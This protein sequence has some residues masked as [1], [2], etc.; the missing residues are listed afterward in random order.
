MR[1]RYT[2]LEIARL[3]GGKLLG[4]NHDTV[5]HYPVMDSRKVVF[6]E[7]SLFIAIHGPH[8]NG[9]QYISD[10]IKQ[11]VK[12]FLVSDEEYIKPFLNQAG[13]IVVKNTLTAFQIIAAS[14]RNE[15]NGS[16]V[17]I[18]GSNGKT[19]VKDWLSHVLSVQ[20]NVC[21]NPKSYNSQVGVPI[22]LWN[23][24]PEHE[25]G[26]FEAGI[27]LPGEMK[28]LESMIRPTLG[29]FTNIGSAHEENF[30][31]QEEKIREKLILFKHSEGIII[32]NDDELIYSIA[33]EIYPDKK[34]ITWGNH[35]DCN[36]HVSFKKQHG[37]CEIFLSSGDENF[38]YEIPFTDAASIENSIHVFIA[39]L[40]LGIN[41]NVLIEQMKLLPRVNMRLSFKS[42]KNNCFIIDDTYSNDFDSLKIAVDSLV[43]LHQFQK[44]TIIL[45]DIVQSKTNK[46]VLYNEVASLLEQKGIQRIIGIGKEIS[47][48]KTLFKGTAWFYPTIHACLDKLNSITFKDEAILIKGARVFEL[49][50][51]VA[52]LE[53]KVH[54]T[55][56]EVNLNAMV[57]N[58]N[59]Y[60]K[61]IPA[62]TKIMAMVKASGYGTGTHEIAH[63]LHFHHIDYLAVAYADEGIELRNH[64]I[65]LPIM[66]MNA[67]STGINTLLENKLEPVIYNF[68]TLA[69]YKNQL[70]R[71]GTLP[72]VHIEIDTGMHRLGFNPSS[73]NQLCDEI[74][75]INGLIVKS[76][77]SHL[78]GSD[79]PGLDEFTREQ[80]KQFDLHSSFIEK[81]LGYK[82]I[83]HIANSAG[84]SRFKEAAFDM[85]RLGVGLYGVGANTEEQSKLQPVI[86]LYS[87][88]AQITEVKPGD[89]IGYGRSFIA[90]KSMKIATVPIGYAD[91]YRRSLGNGQGKMFIN[92]KPANVVG[93]V[94]MDM[95]MID[96]TDLDIS[97]GDRVEIIGENY[98]I[99]LFARSI[100]TIPYEVLTSI[101]QRV[102]RI[103]TQE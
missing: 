69:H 90:N 44:K 11:G 12:C 60:R 30:K 73:I 71:G 23:L 80:I 76:V 14:H 81:A 28:K 91:G 4:K 55:I 93:R 34:L 9:H 1:N 59:Y 15:F 27:S 6:P 10:V 48:F 16:L 3:T 79:E 66:V 24:Q 39:A 86:S 84:A 18:T 52:R 21:K 33:K 58:L 95:T 82:T 17:G 29:I 85:V 57:H 5:V 54:D 20:Y 37:N 26:V 64:G 103:Y 99:E 22:S 67:E 56:L 43:S 35:P 40:Y 72:T 78:A 92:G 61:H 36:Y 77:F 97:V 51:L 68:E 42:G 101:S 75:N 47:E 46:A 88:I 96:V 63:I 74:K 2:F 62:G 31:N 87:T 100:D 41:Y 70:A 8:H 32:R 38:Q 50:K 98:P 53:N 83:R 94:C 102:R 7:S 19:I 45:S 89:S 25:M 49:E 13:F 65:Q